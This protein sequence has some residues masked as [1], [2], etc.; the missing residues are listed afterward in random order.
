MQ[1]QGQL[2]ADIAKLDGQIKRAEATEANVQRFAQMGST[3]PAAETVEA[4]KMTHKY[5]L[6]R[7]LSDAAQGRLSGVEA[8]TPEALR[9]AASYGIQL[10]GNV[11]I[12]Q[13]FIEQRNVYGTD[14][15]QSGVNDAVTTIATEGGPLY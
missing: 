6:Q 12:P 13:S 2:N 1:R 11:C 9:E 15:S 10:R 14:A 4:N 8:E 7:A 5:D 3:A